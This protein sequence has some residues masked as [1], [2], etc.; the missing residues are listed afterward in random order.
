MKVFFEVIE[1]HF[2]FIDF[3]ILETILNF[4]EVDVLLDSLE[5]PHD[6]FGYKVSFFIFVQVI[7]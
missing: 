7:E 6:I 3:G 2:I 5:H 4:I 1:G